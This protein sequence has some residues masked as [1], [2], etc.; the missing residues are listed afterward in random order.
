MT[1]DGPLL[2]IS[3]VPFSSVVTPPVA[4]PAVLHLVD[5]LS[6]MM[7]RARYFPDEGEEEWI[8]YGRRTGGGIGVTDG[9]IDRDY[10]AKYP[11]NEY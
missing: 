2:P 11:G 1:H 9:A 10:V 8:V 6:S 5:E 7:L 4:L 3:C